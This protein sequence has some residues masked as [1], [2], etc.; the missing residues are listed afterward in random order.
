MMNLLRSVQAGQR[1]PATFPK[2][3]RLADAGEPLHAGTQTVTESRS[4]SASA[5]PS[6]P[7]NHGLAS[8]V[9]VVNV[10]L[11]FVHG[12]SDQPPC[13]ALLIGKPCYHSVPMLRSGSVNLLAESGR[14][15]FKFAQDGVHVTLVVSEAAST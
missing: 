2:P 15:R 5:E 12:L 14:S 4:L 3:D 7:R 6:G 1:R 11:T 8:F 9:D 10:L 13:R